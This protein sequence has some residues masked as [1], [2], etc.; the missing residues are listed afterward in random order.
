M[1]LRVDLSYGRKTS[2]EGC[3]EAELEIDLED[4]LLHL[5]LVP[6]KGAR[7]AGQSRSPGE[8]TALADEECDLCCEPRDTK[9]TVKFE[10]VDVFLDNSALIPATELSSGLLKE[11]PLVASF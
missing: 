2:Q 4:P 11:T 10:S 7:R 3:S 6:Q 9:T 1:V 8:W 5:W